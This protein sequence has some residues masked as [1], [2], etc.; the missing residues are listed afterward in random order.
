MLFILCIVNESVSN[1]VQTPLTAAARKGNIEE[2]L[3][4]LR[5]GEYPTPPTVCLFPP[6]V[7]CSSDCTLLLQCSAFLASGSDPTDDSRRK[8]IEQRVSAVTMLCSAYRERVDSLHE[9]V[10]TL[11][12]RV[13][14]SRGIICASA[15][16]VARFFACQ[17]SLQFHVPPW[18]VKL[19]RQRDGRQAKNRAS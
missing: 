12:E 3:K 17:L 14:R 8:R 18:Y 10:D 16:H 11:H 19:E 5:N 4:V 2:V 13:N 7:T 6:L 9:C 1:I 15:R